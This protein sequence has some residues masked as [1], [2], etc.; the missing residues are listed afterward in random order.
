MS[1]LR[2]DAQ[3]VETRWSGCTQHFKAKPFEPQMHCC[4]IIHY[5]PLRHL[6]NFPKAWIAERSFSY[7]WQKKIRI[8]RESE[9]YGC[10][11]PNWNGAR[12]VAG[13][14]AFQVAGQVAFQVAGQV[15]CQVALQVA[16][17]VAVQVACLVA[18]QV[19][20]SY[21]SQ[22]IQGYGS[23]VPQPTC[24]W[25]PDACLLG[26]PTRRW[27]NGQR[28]WSGEEFRSIWNCNGF[29]RVKLYVNIDK[30]FGPFGQ[31]LQ[32]FIWLNPRWCISGAFWTCDDKG[33]EE[34]WP[35]SFFS[36]SPLFCSFISFSIWFFVPSFSVLF[37]SLCFFYFV[38]V[39]H[40]S[41][42]LC[43]QS[44]G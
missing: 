16:C 17:L 11:P 29:N 12:Q 40:F 25:N 30:G 28:C 4:I 32:I 33:C 9:A 7:P 2:T 43:G 18:S 27:H 22:T 10:L 19:Q 13:Q 31:N 6:I 41:F 21:K 39:P 8:N 44:Q 3:I 24:S 26:F 34:N 14:V 37:F 20:S 5:Q 42:P 1:N 15:A 23:R 35:R 36:F 38:F